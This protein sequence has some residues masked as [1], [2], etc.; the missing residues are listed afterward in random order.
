MLAV[1]LLTVLALPPAQAPASATFGGGDVYELP[2]GSV[3][4]K[5]LYVI[6]NE[7]TIDGTVEGDL[8]VVA[9]RV[10]LSGTVRGNT[11]IVAARIEITG[12]TFGIVRTIG[13]AQ[14]IPPSPLPAPAIPAPGA[15]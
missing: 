14:I 12:R 2:A 4:P 5:D 8:A 7:A 3:V 10:W 1:L 13:A 15:P 11:N 6:A 9:R